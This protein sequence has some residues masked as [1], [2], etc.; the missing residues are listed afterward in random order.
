MTPRLTL[1]VAR[2]VLLQIRHDHRTLAMLVVVPSLILGL[3]WWMFRDVGGTGFDAL[4]PALLAIIPFVVMFL[5]TSV[6][7]LR[8]R[9]GGTLERLLAMPMGKLDFLIAEHGEAIPVM[10]ALKKTMDPDNIMNPGK[11]LKMN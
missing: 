8:E 3:L 2:R 9:S 4:G 10:R 6:T 5:V 1:A 11:I 7:T